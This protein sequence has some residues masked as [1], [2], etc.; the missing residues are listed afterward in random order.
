MTQEVPG[1]AVPIGQPD[2]PDP[3]RPPMQDPSPERPPERE[4]STPPPVSDPP[5]PGDPERETTRG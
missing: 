4:P 1:R 2:G 5:K 3:S